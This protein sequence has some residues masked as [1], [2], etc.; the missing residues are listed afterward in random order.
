MPAGPAVG[1]L[2]GLLCEACCMLTCGGRDARESSIGPLVKSLG[3]SLIQGP[4]P[5][6]WSI[7]CSLANKMVV[8]LETEDLAIDP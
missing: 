2:L 7:I 4:N 6:Y 3:Q 8:G 5:V 1:M